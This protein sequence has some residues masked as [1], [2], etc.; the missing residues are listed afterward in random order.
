[1][2]PLKLPQIIYGTAWKEAAT[3]KLVSEALTAGFLAIDTAYQK[4]HYREDFVGEALLGLESRGMKRED[5]FLQ[6]KYTY[7]EGQ[8]H[9]LPYDPKSDFKTQVCASFANTLKNLHTDYLD[10]YLLHGPRYAEG[11]ADSDWEVWAAMEELHRSGQARSIGVSNVNIGQLTELHEKSSLKPQMVQNRCY[12]VRGWDRQVR[13]YCIRHKIVYQGFSLLTANPQ[14]VADPRVGAIARR[15]KMTP[16]QSILRFATRIGILPLT[17][18]TNPTHMKE[19]LDAMHLDLTAD[20][21]AAIL[22]I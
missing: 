18:T 19:D 22:A 2:T 13:E 16:Q 1:M 15:L 14:V 6:S 4:K 5:L 21:I 12:A 20:D 3:A 9:R 8:D 17:G 10:S 7:R 11:L